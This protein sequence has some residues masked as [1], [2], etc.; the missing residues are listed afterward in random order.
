MFSLM[1]LQNRHFLVR[2]K[3]MAWFILLSL[4]NID[5]SLIFCGSFVNLQSK[6]AFPNMRHFHQ[7]WA[8]E[9]WNWS[10]NKKWKVKWFFLKVKS[11][12]FKISTANPVNGRWLQN[13]IQ[14]FW[15]WVSGKSVKN[16]NLALFPPFSSSF[17]SII[18]IRILSPPL[19][20]V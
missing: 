17:T 19:W 12:S 20:K 5:Y 3:H 9:N 1:P 13:W 14:K 15:N 4:I 18:I 16:R 11:Y 10:S 7:H 8:L 2:T 6:F